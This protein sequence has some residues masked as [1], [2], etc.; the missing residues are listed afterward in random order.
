LVDI[1]FIPLLRQQKIQIGGISQGGTVRFLEFSNPRDPVALGKTTPEFLTASVAV[2]GG[3]LY[4]ISLLNARILLAK[5]FES[6]FKGKK[7]YYL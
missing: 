6:T 5:S 7:L 4:N 2:S 1:P 3:R